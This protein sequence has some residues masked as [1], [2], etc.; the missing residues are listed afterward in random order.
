MRDLLLID[1]RGRTWR[2]EVPVTRRERMR[3]LLGRDSLDADHG[4]LFPRSR[5]VH[6]IGMR[7]PITV[8]FL[9]AELRVL[10]VLAAPPG[11]LFLTHRRATHVLEAPASAH[12]RVGEVL[13]RRRD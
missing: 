11:R 13:A 8:V 12:F 7:F 6:T 1:P 9:D 10:R 4:M 3:G 5:S 2:V